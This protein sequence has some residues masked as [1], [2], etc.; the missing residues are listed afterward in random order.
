MFAALFLLNLCL[1]MSFFYSEFCEE[2]TIRYL[3][4]NNEY[5]PP[6]DVDWPLK[7]RL[8]CYVLFW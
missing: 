4:K 6:E 2:E 7:E 8:W 5:D 1:F 3:W